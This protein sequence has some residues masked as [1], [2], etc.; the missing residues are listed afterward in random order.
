MAKDI[1]IRMSTDSINDAIKEL[2]KLYADFMRKL[3]LM[4]RALSSDGVAIALLAIRES[5]GSSG[6]AQISLGIDNR[7]DIVEAEIQ[8]TGSEALFIEFGAGIYYNPTDPPHA[9]EHSMGV[10]TYPGQTHAFNAGWFYYDASGEKH[11]TH[12]T[13]ATSPMLHASDNYRNNA[14]KMALS[15]FRS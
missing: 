13:L 2:R 8:M 7:G 10:G 5:I 15:I 9:S 3:D 1:T 11:Y 12:G 6:D 14:I 4:V